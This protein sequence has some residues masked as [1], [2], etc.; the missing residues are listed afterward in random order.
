MA[1]DTN[2]KILQ[3]N[4]GATGTSG[5]YNS[6]ERPNG[7]VTVTGT[8]TGFGS[9]PTVTQFA[10][11]T[12]GTNGEI[13]SLSSQEI[14]SPFDSGSYQSAPFLQ[15]RYFTLEDTTGASIRE[16]GTTE[17]TNRLTGFTKEHPAFSEYLLAYDMGVPPGRTFSAASTENTLPSQS[18]LKNFWLSDSPLGDIATDVVAVSYAGSDQWVVSGNGS[19][20]PIFL[21]QGFSFSR[22]TSNLVAQKPGAD[23][24]TDNGVTEVVRTLAT[25]TEVKIV[26][27][28]PTFKN[29]GAS[30]QYTHIQMWSGNGD[31]NKSQHLYRWFYLATGANARARMELGNN[32]TYTSCTRRRVVPHATWSDTT[33]TAT[34]DG[35]QLT[36][37]THWFV[38]NADGTRTS[39]TI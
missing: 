1:K 20:P 7:L 9:P 25:G 33:V 13:V 23:P 30:E 28:Q 21:V 18:G 5:F 29:G 6:D 34:V 14:G 15:S 17:A 10:K 31:Q 2:Q 3:W 4:S 37:M 35:F 22:W 38:T 36:N 16:G 24:D 27:D 11:W 8:G 12:N 26:T 32:A 19:A 39:G